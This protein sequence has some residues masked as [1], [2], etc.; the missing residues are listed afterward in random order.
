M[1]IN[2]FMLFFVWRMAYCVVREK[3]YPVGQ[4]PGLPVKKKTI[5]PVNC[6]TNNLITHYKLPITVFL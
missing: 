2:L 5:C 4:L 1:N 6:V 3:S